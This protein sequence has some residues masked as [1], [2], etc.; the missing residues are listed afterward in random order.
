MRD[1]PQYFALLHQRPTAASAA[2]SGTVNIVRIIALP[3]AV[4][5]L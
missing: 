1:Q 4:I 3:V 5:G 2:A